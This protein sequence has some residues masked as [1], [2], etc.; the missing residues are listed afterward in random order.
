M[1]FSGV[2]ISNPVPIEHIRDPNDPRLAPYHIVRDPELV[3]RSDCFLAEGRH[4]VRTLLSQRSHA[5]ES[6]LLT[7]TALADLE[8]DLHACAPDVPCFVLAPSTL[9]A[10]GNISF[11]QG[12]LALGRRPAEEPVRRFVART[13]GA[14]W[15]GFDGVGNP[16]NVGAVFRSA[17]A[18]GAQA[19][20]LSENSC[21][22]LYRK[23]IRSAMGAS[24]VL[25]FLHAHEDWSAVLAVVRQTRRVVW[26]LTPDEDAQPLDAALAS[27]RP[28][29]DRLLVLG[30]EGDGVSAATRSVADRRVRIPMVSQTDSINVAAAAAIALYALRTWRTLAR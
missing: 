10:I 13:R 5:I 20:L 9:Q 28:D 30:A 27:A 2:S 12:C 23:A 1:R 24:L 15:V 4:V 19:A 3:R 8:A 21:S 7:P 26:A 14:L 16:D 22:P 6:L 25:P 17:R 18:L 11:H 29:E